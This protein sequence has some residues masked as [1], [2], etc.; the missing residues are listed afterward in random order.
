MTSPLNSDRKNNKIVSIPPHSDDHTISITDVSYDMNGE[1]AIPIPT[2]DFLSSPEEEFVARSFS[3]RLW[4][5]DPVVTYSPLRKPVQANGFPSPPKLIRQTNAYLQ[6]S[7]SPYYSQIAN[8][9]WAMQNSVPLNDMQST[10]ASS[11][12]L[13]FNESSIEEAIQRGHVSLREKKSS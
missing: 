12:I 3:S 10:D 13:M 8:N 7:H 6:E 1:V 9:N 4:K 2:Q 5:D 11:S